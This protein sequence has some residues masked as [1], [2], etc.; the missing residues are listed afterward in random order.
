MEG[1][2]LMQFSMVTDIYF[3]L[4]AISGMTLTPVT[5]SEF[6]IDDLHPH[7]REK[8]LATAVASPPLPLRTRAGLLASGL[9]PR[10]RSFRSAGAAAA[11]RQSQVTTRLT[12]ES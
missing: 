10:G 2:Q 9:P 6:V 8:Q 11:A 7:S 3:C 5:T 12:P 1:S 4:N